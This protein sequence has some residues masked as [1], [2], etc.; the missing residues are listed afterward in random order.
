[1]AGGTIDSFLIWQLTGGDTHVTDISN[2]SRTSLMNIHSGQW[3]A[4]MLELFEVPAGI[5]PR[6]APSSG[7]LGYTRGSGDCPTASR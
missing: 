2:A 4:T 7:I 6:I 3:D 5:L 1:M